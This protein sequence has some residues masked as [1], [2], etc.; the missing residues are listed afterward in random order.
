[1]LHDAI[2]VVKGAESLLDCGSGRDASQEGFEK[3]AGRT[4]VKF[5]W[6]RDDKGERSDGWSSYGM[7][8]EPQVPPLRSGCLSLEWL[9]DGKKLQAP[10]DLDSLRSG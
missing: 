4:G 3:A 8:K 1:M 6:F 5:T 7:G 2:T 10:L 9:R